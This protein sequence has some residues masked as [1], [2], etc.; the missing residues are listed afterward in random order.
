MTSTSKPAI[1]DR[2]RHLSR[3]QLNDPVPPTHVLSNGQYTTVITGAGTGFSAFGGYALTRWNADRVEDAEGYFL[4]LRDLESGTVWSVGYQPMQ[5][6][7]LRYDVWL[8]INRVAIT[9]LD[10][11]IELRMQAC[12][13]PDDNLELRRY[14]LR[15]HSDRPRRIELTSYAEVVLNLRAADRAHPA[16]SKLFIQTEYLPEQR[17]LL[18]KRRPRSTGEKPIYMIHWSVGQHRDKPLQYETDRAQFVGRGRSLANP[19]ALA[20]R[21]LLSG[22]VGAV[23][24]PIV[25]L[26]QVIELKPGAA[27]MLTFGL[28]VARTR[29]HAITLVQRYREAA[30]VDQTIE[31][32]PV[33]EHELL[34]CLCISPDEAHDFQKLAGALLYGDPRLRAAEEILLHGEGQPSDL[35]RYGLTGDLPLV[36]AHVTH[37]AQK[38]VVK[39]LVK[40]HAF[41]SSKGLPVDLLFLVDRSLSGGQDSIREDS[42]REDSIREDAVNTCQ[43]QQ[44]SSGAGQIIVRCRDELPARDLNLVQTV[45]R[46]VIHDSFPQWDQQASVAVGFR[47]CLKTLR[48]QTERGVRGRKTGVYTEVHEDFE[49][50]CNKVMASAAVFKQLLSPANAYF[51]S[52]LSIPDPDMPRSE[53][54]AEPETL[55]F[56]N[57]YGGFTED[58]K[59]YVIRLNPDT[60]SGI[61][62]PPLP[63]INVVA[64]E[65]VGFIASESGSGFTWTQNSRE[66]RLTPWYNDP[67]TDPHGEALYIRDEEA[68]IFWSPLAGPVPQKALYV[69]RHGFGYSRY[70]HRSQELDQELCLFVPRHDPVKIT[71]LCLHN[72]SNRIRHLSLFAYQRLVM[73]TLASHSAPFI[74]TYYDGETGA[75]LAMN[76]YRGE[77]AERVAFSAVVAPEGAQGVHFTGDRT[78]FLGRNG[79]P[80][81]PAAVS[82]AKILDGRTGAGLDPCMAFQ[83]L[84]ELAPG[85]TLECAFLL[86]EAASLEAVHTLIAR[87]Q[88]VSSIDEAL[89]QVRTFWE[90]TLSA[91][92]IDTPSPAIDLMVNG[93]LPYQTLSCRIWARSAFYQSGGAFGFRDQLQDASALVYL[94]PGLT[95]DQILLHAAHQF[96]EGDVL[97]W[98]HPPS[99]RGIRTRFSDDLLWLPFVT[100]FYVR[101][102]GDESIL[103]QTVKFITARALEKDEDE[104]YLVPADSGH[105]A[106]VYEHC[107]RSIDRS[108]TQGA[109]GLPLMGT[110]DWNDGMNRV[111]RA[112]RGES[113]WL[114]FFI[115]DILN[116][117]I[118]ICEQRGDHERK[119]RYSAYRAHLLKV[120]NDAGWD[121]AWYRRAYYDDGTPLGSA[122]N[123]ECQIDALAQAWA[124]ISRAAPPKRI[125]QAM[126]ALE[127]YLVSEQE[128]LIRLLTPAFDK[129]PHDPGYIKGYVPGVRENGGQYTHGALWAV[130][131]LAEAARAERVGHLLEMLSPISHAR[132]PQHVALYRVEPYVIAADIYGASPHVGRGGW[133]WYTGSA[134]WMYRV[135]LE[136][137]LGFQLI[138]GRTVLLKPRIPNTW[139][140]FTIRYRLADGETTYDISVRNETSQ[141]GRVVA[142]T[143]DSG[144][145]EVENGVARIPLLQD[146]AHH[147]VHV[148]LG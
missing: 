138:E 117:F 128:G 145:A 115:Y 50:E 130:K 33:K 66:N 125:E 143:V 16:F 87:Y 79:S 54:A 12:V 19:V 122:Q 20:S 119:A 111:G 103:E 46:I 108:L 9:R 63:W 56:D 40:A 91:I 139:T 147:D 38:T 30:S 96:V 85:E 116:N 72:L 37:A 58:G 77:F 49:P 134:G 41:W 137:L 36:V 70:W 78:A 57:G 1:Q 23:L 136:S 129:T 141:T 107:C 140:G 104:A 61:R 135:T 11:E 2:V 124:V 3:A 81:R 17:A 113:V 93:W 60:L 65:S 84:L 114:G 105:A 71:R 55:L 6:T 59:E 132:T 75:I 45:A 27:R 92:E 34:Q 21:E 127:K 102:T 44:P 112:G 89:A 8:E 131:A 90:N 86:G 83:V 110:G 5:H 24:D 133:S 98:W 62:R 28:G 29:K 118:P 10:Y 146:G 51:R 67:I 43:A 101:T 53:D 32:A 73:G 35:S 74:N 14:T 95:R 15:N 144:T 106:D 69:V 82:G 121:G 26:R 88:N 7:A 52:A 94:L 39:T 148:R 76:R 99:S 109:H 47:S 25:S 126:D 80:Q 31:R 123:D 120:L 42:I 142:V 97:H 48:A 22:T 13:A 4:Y 68:G 100:A 18:A 64:N